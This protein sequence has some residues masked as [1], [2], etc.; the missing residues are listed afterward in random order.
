MKVNT[1]SMILGSWVQVTSQ[2]RMLDIG[3]GTGILA[4]M[5]AQKAAP[6]AVID[7]I[8]ID[9]D[10]AAQA[11]E[12][13]LRSP[14]AENINTCQGCVLSQAPARQ[15][16]LIVS[17]PPYFDSVQKHSRAYE[18]QSAARKQARQ[19]GSLQPE[20]LF[21]W[22]NAYLDR[23]GDFYCLYPAPAVQFLIPQAEAEGLYC[24]SLL[25]VQSV[26]EKPAYVAALR[27]RREPSIV[28][29]DNIIIHNEAGEY[30][31]AFKAL[32]RDYYLNF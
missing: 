22:V 25:W 1:D 29:K 18:K 2:T 27:F 32:C 31:E 14:W 12:N 16:D 17:N 13:V 19:T 4:L 24:D 26:A 20:A 11:R 5:L 23:D 28:K 15:Y 6:D 7:A 9:A 10:A 8:D 3:T 30:S 21:H